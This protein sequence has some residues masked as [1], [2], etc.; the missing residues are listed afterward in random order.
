MMMITLYG[1]SAIVIAHTIL[2]YDRDQ[3]PDPLLE[4]RLFAININS[5][6]Q[7]ACMSKL[8]VARGDSMN[9]KC[10]TP[11]KCRVKFP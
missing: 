6:H 2:E 7:T 9:Y 10:N 1:T 11:V 4:N 5:C 8:S 3:D